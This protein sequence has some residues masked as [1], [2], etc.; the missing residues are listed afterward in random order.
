MREYFLLLETGDKMLQES[1]TGDNYRLLLDVVVQRG[2]T[3]MRSLQQFFPLP[4]E[5]ETIL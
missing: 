1:S 4:M 5:D 2:K 3:A